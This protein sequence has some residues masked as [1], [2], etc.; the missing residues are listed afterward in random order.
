VPNSDVPISATLERLARRTMDWRFFSWYWGDA[1]AVDGLLAAA[2]VLG[3]NELGRDDLRDY[4]AQTLDRWDSQCLPCLDDALAPG[5]AIARLTGEGILGDRAASRFLAAVD[6]LPLLTGAVPALEPHRPAYRFGVCIDALYHLPAGLAAIGRLR[7][8]DALVRRAVTIAEQ[9]LRL[10][11]CPDGWAQWHDAALRRN[12]AIC[13]S[14]GLGWALLGCLDTIEVAGSTAPV[15]VLEDAAG[16]ILQA[17]AATQLPDGHWPAVLG[18]SLPWCA[19]ET[20]TA[21][22]FVAGAWH[23]A[24]PAAMQ[25]D[26]VRRSLRACLTAVD[27]GGVYTG[28]SADV[29]PSF[30]IGDY[31]SFRVEPS[32]WGQGAALRA[33]AAGAARAAGEPASDPPPGP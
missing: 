28:V 11:S 5:V 20:S 30:E 1:I 32:P 7:G 10:T 9:I 2:D 27:S 4:V 23:R 26:T 24:A 29:L 33:L 31:L 6:R 19:A 16:R 22:F 14:R 3:R 8:D 12:N 18:S 25:Q 17:L 13:W 21:A 15:A